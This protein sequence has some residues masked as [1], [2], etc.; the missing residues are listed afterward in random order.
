MPEHKNAIC[1]YQ[2]KDS[3]RCAYADLLRHKV[4]AGDDTNDT[5]QEINEQ[6]AQVSK[7][8]L[9]EDTQHEKVEHVQPDVQ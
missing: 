2:P 1:S 6:E 3:S 8:S 9:Q 5:G 7:Q 4:E